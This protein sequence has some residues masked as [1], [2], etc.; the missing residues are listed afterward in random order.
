MSIYET[1][2]RYLIF[3]LGL[4]LMAIGVSLS[5][6]S[7]LGTSPIS[8]VPY[9]LSL[10]LPMTIG[11]F[12][13]IMNI[14]L[15]IFQICLLR[16]QY[17]WI[18]LLQVVVAIIFAYFTDFT[19]GLFSWINV[20]TYPAQLGLFVLSCLVLALGVSFEVTANVVMM[21]GEG[22]VSAISIV[23]KKEFGKIKVAFDVTL[24]ICGFLLSLILFHRLNGIREGTIIAALLV[25]TVVRFINKHLSFMDAFI[26]GNDKTITV[27][28]GETLLTTAEKI[29]PLIITINREYGSGGLDIG[30]KIAEDLGI[31]FYDRQLLDKA[32]QETGI[33]EELVRENDQ[34]IPHLLLN[35]LS[36]QEY[37]FSK[38]E[39]SPLDA[40]YE[41]E[42]KF[43]INLAHTESC[44]I[45]GHCSDSIL[46]G[47]PNVFNVFIHADK[48]SRIKR[49]Q[50]E[51]GIPE[52]DIEE[53]LQKTDK[54]R[55]TYYQIYAKRKWG[56]IRNYDLTV[57]STMFGL[58][59]TS[60]LIE[61]AIKVKVAYQ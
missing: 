61:E 35:Q 40:I 6:R 50:Y 59:K 41:A 3:I 2:K 17:K 57:N 12:T 31:S 54:A 48:P 4:F 56:R 25:G 36:A 38:Q 30:H 18:Q 5:T 29:H 42:K 10:G 43:I 33:N 58:E 37:A 47:F 53:T 13:F 16:K 22:M 55:E 32:I 19:M 8:C 15:I 7:N 49:I 46:A 60:Q 26:K 39:K 21:A 28:E 45:M 11:Q 51:Y 20:T 52:K 1:I 27:N 23:T 9:V 14:A 24:V 44:V 34:A